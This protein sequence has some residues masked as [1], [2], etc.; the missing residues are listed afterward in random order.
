MIKTPILI[1]KKISIITIFT[2]INTIY[3]FSLGPPVIK[4]ISIGAYLGMQHSNN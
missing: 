3:A 2:R 1:E 4:A